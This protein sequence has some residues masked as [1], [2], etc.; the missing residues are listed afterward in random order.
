MKEEGEIVGVAGLHVLGE[1]L[2][3]VRSLVVSHTYA[4]KGIGR[5]LV[6]HII[7]EAA[8]IKVSRVI[9]LTYETEFF[10][11]AFVFVNRD[12]LPEK[13]WIDCRH[14]PKVDYCDEVA[15]IRYVR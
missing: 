12:A 2:A 7:N 15:M 1:D 6:N 13:V 9:S 4:G 3:E 14:C 10:K 5:M 11:S 8:K